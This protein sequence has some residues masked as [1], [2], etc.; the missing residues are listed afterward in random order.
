MEADTKD[1]IAMMK[2]KV[3]VRNPNDILNMDQTP[4]PYFYHAY[5]TLD[6]NGAKTI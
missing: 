2:E 4:V 6:V 1:F 3:T 5:K